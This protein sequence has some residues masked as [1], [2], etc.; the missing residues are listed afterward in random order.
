MQQDSQAFG[1]VLILFGAVLI[2]LMPAA[3]KFAYIDGANPLM[4]LLG[5]SVIGVAVLLIFIYA[6]GRQP[7]ITFQNMRLAIP[8]AIA[9]V[10]AAIGILTS[11]VY[12]DISLASIIIFLYPFP[13]AIIAH[14]RGETPLTPATIGLMVLATLGLAL[15]LGLE[16]QNTD[17]IG[18]ALAAM[19][20]IAFTVM[21]L[22][23]ADLT[24]VVGAPN[25]NLLMTLWAAIFFAVVSVIGP[26]MGALDPL[27][28]PAS[29][30]GWIS[31]AG[32]G[33]TFSLGYLAFFIS[34]RIIGAARASLLSTSEPVMI[35]LVAVVLVG[36]TLQPLQWLG[37]A[38]VIVSLTL[39]EVTRRPPGD[40]AS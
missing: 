29:L 35:I 25:S 15:V 6:T 24:E 36:E 8:A 20:L 21:I 4:A 30:T 16:W 39:T 22:S 32:V 31:I 2:G 23:M 18:V 3:A 34:V 26:A 28:L 33:I 1:L 37:V 40:A 11:I 10:C 38:I 17:P 13:I 7:G 14:L 9:H 27:A 19:A 5:R 12:I